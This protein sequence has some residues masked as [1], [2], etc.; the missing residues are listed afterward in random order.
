MANIKT[1]SDWRTEDAYWRENYK[2]RPYYQSGY[3]YE[4]YGPAYRFGY[5]AS[6][7][8]SGKQWNDVERDLERDWGSYE[9]RGQS[10]WEQIKAAVRD[11]WDRMVGNR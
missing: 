8:Y 9:Q 5:D 4:D 1:R 2:G 3:D 11:A 6:D 7:R 10:T